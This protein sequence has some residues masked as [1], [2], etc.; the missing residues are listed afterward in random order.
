[1]A[2]S[3]PAAAGSELQQGK[4]DGVEIPFPSSDGLG[5]HHGDGLVELSKVHPWR[6]WVEVKR[7]EDRERAGGG[8]REEGEAAR[9]EEGAPRWWF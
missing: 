7:T 8:G 3:I 6:V 1:M 4:E 2:T 5:G 9:V